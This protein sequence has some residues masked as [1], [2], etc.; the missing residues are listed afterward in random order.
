MKYKMKSNNDE[1]W[2]MSNDYCFSFYISFR[3][4]SYSKP[5]LPGI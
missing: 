3:S 2:V 4:F 5:I 1:P